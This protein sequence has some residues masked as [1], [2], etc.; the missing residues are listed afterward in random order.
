MAYRSILVFPDDTVK[1]IIDSIL[2][3]K[4]SL[5]IKMFVFS[6]PQLIYGVI[7]AHNRGVDVKV[8]LNPAR[9]RE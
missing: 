2:A 7:D 6:D 5:R 1:V 9:R 3:A 8:M 4:T